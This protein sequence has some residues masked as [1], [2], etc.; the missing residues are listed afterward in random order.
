MAKQTRPSRT[1]TYRGRIPSG[2]R[3]QSNRRAPPSQSPNAKS[4]TTLDAHAPPHASYAARVNS[5]S[6][7][8]ARTPRPRSSESSS[9]RLSMRPSNTTTR[10]GPSRFDDCATAG[11]AAPAGVSVHASPTAS[12]VQWLG[13]LATR[14]LAAPFRRRTAPGSIGP[15]SSDRMP[16]IV[17]RV[18]PA[19][20]RDLMESSLGGRDDVPPGRRLR[21]PEP[22]GPLRGIARGDDR[23]V[24]L[25][26]PVVRGVV[27][28]LTQALHPGMGAERVALHADAQRG[29]NPPAP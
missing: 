2:S 7:A 25:V 24:G 11:P 1:C 14:V 29:G 28:H 8:G 18:P 27:Q 21:T 17:R 4:P 5:A 15:S 16:Q 23:H 6:P 3:A 19:D 10:R 20:V 13:R 9:R 12:S 26:A 22:G